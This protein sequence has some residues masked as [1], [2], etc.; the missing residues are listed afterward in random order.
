LRESPEHSFLVTTE[1][2]YRQIAAQLPPQF[3]IIDRGPW[4]LKQGRTLV[5]VGDTTKSLASRSGDAE[6]K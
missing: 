5:L 6:R 2:D 3:G 1:E 4:F